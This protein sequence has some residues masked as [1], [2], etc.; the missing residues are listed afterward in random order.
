VKQWTRQEFAKGLMDGRGRPSRIR[1]Y[2]AKC[3]LREF[4]FLALYGGLIALLWV[5]G[6]GIGAWVLV[7]FVLGRCVRDFAW[8]RQ[9][10]RQPSLLDEF[11]DWKKVEEVAAEVVVADKPE[12]SVRE[13]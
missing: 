9:F 11:L 12:E 7:G 2:Y 13:K 3:W 8:V 5:G 6:Q 1:D 10:N 4:G